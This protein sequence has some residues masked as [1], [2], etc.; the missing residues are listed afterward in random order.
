MGEFVRQRGAFRRLWESGS[1][2][3]ASLIYLYKGPAPLPLAPLIFVK[4]RANK[5]PLSSI[6]IID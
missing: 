6:H 5:H 4:K 1:S 3:L 2:R